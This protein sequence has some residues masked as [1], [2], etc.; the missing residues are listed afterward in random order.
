MLST[1]TRENIA[2]FKAD[3]MVITWII[4]HETEYDILSDEIPLIA[5]FMGPTWGPSGADRTQVGPMLAPWTL[6][7]G[8]PKLYF[9]VICYVWIY[10]HLQLMISIYINILLSNQLTQVW[11]VHHLNPLDS[12]WTMP[13]NCCSLMVL[14]WQIYAWCLVSKLAAKKFLKWFDLL[15]VSGTYETFY[16]FIPF[17]NSPVTTDGGA[18]TN[19]MAHGG[20]LIW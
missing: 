15:F 3:E 16:H 9:V 19:T 4:H 2:L 5:R 1:N 6:L 17:L 11:P 14:Y 10:Y 20:Q 12:E 18:I 7:L 13:V 8:T